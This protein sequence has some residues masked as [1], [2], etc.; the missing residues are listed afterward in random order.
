MSIKGYVDK[1][2]KDNKKVKEP[3]ILKVVVE[4]CTTL[5]HAWDLKKFIHGNINHRNAYLLD[6]AKIRIGNLNLG[7]Q[8]KEFTV[9]NDENFRAPESY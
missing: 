9:E 3:I 4:A 7:S 1:K 2:K 6:D 8:K 5:E